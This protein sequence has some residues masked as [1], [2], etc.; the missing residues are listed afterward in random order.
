MMDILL[1]SA[2]N[3]PTSG[4]P[5]STAQILIGVLGTLG[6]GA[7]GA[8][9]ITGIFS[10]KKLSADAT[11][12]ITRAATSVVEGLNDDN[13][14]LK[15][16]LDEHRIQLARQERLRQADHDEF[17]RV[18]EEHRAVLQLHTAWDQIVK[19]RLAIAGISDIPDPPPF[20]PPGGS[21]ATLMRRVD[22]G[23]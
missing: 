17:G 14:R 20:Y 19:E 1:L 22:S 15:E 11:E 5:L 6:L 12:I 10:K 18:L 21:P 3:A 8:A 16:A 23:E 13:R 7:V 9:V 2:I 4:I